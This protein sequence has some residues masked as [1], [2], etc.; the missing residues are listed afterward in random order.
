MV[1]QTA[2]FSR[3]MDPIVA[4]EDVV[5][6]D[7]SCLSPGTT[8][9]ELPTSWRWDFGTSRLPTPP[10]ASG[11]RDQSPTY[12]FPAP[13]MYDVTL[14]VARADRESEVALSVHV[15]GGPV[16]AFET[17]K[18]A[19]FTAPATLQFVDRSSFDPADPIVAW[20]WDFGGWGVSTQQNP[21][22]V[23]VGQVG[24]W[25]IRLRITTASGQSRLVESVLT[26]E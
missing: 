11:S 24:D 17:V 1:A 6:T 18:A 14:R 10:A 13:G 20:S 2:Q 16:A 3:D 21:G 4:G 26:V 12:R 22:P 23:I 7:E 9:C 15:V 19:P 5:F 8:G 25:L